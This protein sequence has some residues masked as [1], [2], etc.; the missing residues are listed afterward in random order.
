MRSDVDN[1]ELEKKAYLEDKGERC[2]CNNSSSND[3]IKEEKNNQWALNKPYPEV[4]VSEKN[5]HYADILSNDF[6]GACSEM[7]AVTQYLNHNIR[8]GIINREVSA[9]LL[10]ISKVE[11]KHLDIIGE[12]IVL[13]GGDLYYGRSKKD[14]FQCWS[15]KFINYGK[16]LR[17]MLKFDIQSEVDAIVQ[18][19]KHIEEIEDKHIKKILYRIIEDEEFH[20]E[21]LDGLLKKINKKNT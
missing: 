7:T 16:D 4:M 18:Y 15:P 17:G 1:M 19:K 12:L 3:D 11:M 10:E 21:I 6:A 2:N 14:K 13:L 5:K 8:L 9:A 20:I